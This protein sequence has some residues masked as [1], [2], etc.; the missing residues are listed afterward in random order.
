L[1]IKKE[2]SSL[3]FAPKETN[4]FWELTKT[5]N[6]GR[7]SDETSQEIRD[8]HT[9]LNKAGIPTFLIIDFDYP[10]FHT[11]HDTEDKCSAES[12]ENVLGVVKKYLYSL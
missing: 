6:L 9:A 3:T 12:L 1:K 11:T 2:P 10:Y 8:D 4:T 5:L 7:F